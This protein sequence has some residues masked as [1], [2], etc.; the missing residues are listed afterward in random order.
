M[1]GSKERTSDKAKADK[2]GPTDPCTKAGGK[3]TK[4][5]EKEGLSML[6]VMS[7]TASGRMTRLMD[8]VS[9]AI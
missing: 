5:T 1:I 4:L 9:T 3:T 7:M 2:Y 8:M 6:M